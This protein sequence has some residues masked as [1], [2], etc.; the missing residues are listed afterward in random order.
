MKYVKGLDT[1]RAFAVI[2]V[3]VHHWGLP[4]PPNAV[5]SYVQR[6]I[7][8]DGRFGVDLFFVLSGYLIT[9]ILLEARAS[10]G[11][12]N[13]NIIKSFI[14]R[15]A[16]R[17][18]PIFYAAILILFLANYPFVRDHVAWFLTYTSNILCYREESWNSFSHTW[19]LSVE[20]QFYLLW[21]WLIVYVRQNHLKYI[22]VLAIVLGLG[23]TFYTVK[24]LHNSFGPVLMPSCMQAFGIGG[25]YAYVKGQPG[26]PERFLQMLRI[27]FPLALVAHFYWAFSPDGGHL[28]YW[29]RTANSIVG[30]WL[31]HKVVCNRSEWVRRT[32][33]ENRFLN[34][35]GQ[36]SYGIY[37]YHY[38]LPDIYAAAV[39]ECFQAVP[40]V[41]TMLSNL[42]CSYVL[43]CALL[44]FLS[45]GSFRF[46]EK[47]VMKLKVSFPY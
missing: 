20:E 17:I 2:F 40:S 43:K 3:I 28:N 31:V 18:F 5:V 36:I 35:V 45:W 32:L 1:L 44:L 34:T 14:V 7:I 19:S 11:R 23:T 21:P 4:L 30:I 26:F 16:L 13:L 24:V 38:A 42:Y 46:F 33:L 15:R 8:P 6:V 41:Q 47:P 22:F 10:H 9:S 29:Y 12:G 25:I 27:A 37:L 39:R